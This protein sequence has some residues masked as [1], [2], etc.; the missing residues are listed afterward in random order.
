VHMSLWKDGTPAFYDPEAD[1][2]MSATMRAFTGGLLTYLSDYTV[3]F[4]P[5]VNSYKRFKVGSFAPTRKVWS[6]DNRTAAYR[7]CGDGSKGIRMECRLPGA[8]MNPYLTIAGMLA[9]GL[10]GIEQGLDCGDP[11][12][13]DAYAGNDDQ[14]PMTLRAATEA[15]RGSDML[16]AAFGDEVVDHYARAA[17]WEQQAFDAVVTD[18]EIARG[19]ERA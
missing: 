7:L 16:R 6:V 5:Y 12:A 9:A 19:F 15:L 13:G 10:A 3:L 4:A 14:I 11:S 2:G 18:W 17:E 1:L 8:D